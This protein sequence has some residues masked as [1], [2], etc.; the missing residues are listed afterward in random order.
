VSIPPSGTGSPPHATAACWHPLA[1][2]AHTTLST[3]H[4]EERETVGITRETS[5]GRRNPA[6]AGAVAT[7]PVEPAAEH[8]ITDGKS[9]IHHLGRHPGDCSAPPLSGN[10]PA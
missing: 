3:T 6:L 2:R 10:F 5:D 8:R 1:T 4:E 7:G 9:M